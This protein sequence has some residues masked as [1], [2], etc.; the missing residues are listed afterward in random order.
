MLG[1]AL[2]VRALA[3][4]VLF[5]PSAVLAW[6]TPGALIGIA[7]GLLI[8]MAAVALP[9]PA[10]LAFAG[11]AL[12]AATVL[13]NIAPANPYLAQALQVWPQGN[14]LNFNGLTHLVSSLWP[15]AAMAYLLLVATGR[16]QSDAS[17]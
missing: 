7:A 10:K 15:F 14:F 13:V 16:Q 9:R 11:M 12:M 17:S 4:S 8:A 2:V 6:M 3:F 1:C 5:N